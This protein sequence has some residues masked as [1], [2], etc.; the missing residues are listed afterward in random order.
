MRENRG[1][2]F[3]AHRGG[4]IIF[5]FSPENNHPFCLGIY[6][7]ISPLHIGP[8]IVGGALNFSV[9]AQK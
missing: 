3:G 2:Y 8:G 4:L 1:L 5:E 6:I 7:K 9:F